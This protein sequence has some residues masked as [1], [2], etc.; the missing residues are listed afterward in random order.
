[1]GILFV[2]AVV[3]W[4]FKGLSRDHEFQKI[5]LLLGAFHKCV[6]IVYFVA[7]VYL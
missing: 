1:M 7:Y 6:A 4:G 5:A 2:C 3:V